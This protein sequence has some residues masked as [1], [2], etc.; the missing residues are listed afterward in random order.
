VLTAGSNQGQE[1]DTNYG[2]SRCAVSGE[3]GPAAS[4]ERPGIEQLSIKVQPGGFVPR[5]DAGLILGRK[6]QTLR[7][8]KMRGFGPEPIVIGGQVFYRLED[9]FEFIRA[10]N[11]PERPKNSTEAVPA[12]LE[13]EEDA[14]TCDGRGNFVS[15]RRGQV[16]AGALKEKCT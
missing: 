13:P 6:P 3:Q 7:V 5:R 4:E 14:P 8:W 12:E 1:L 9:I 16:G 15:A 11:A 10:E 2:V